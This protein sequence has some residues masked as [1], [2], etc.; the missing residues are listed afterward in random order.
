MHW[1]RK[2]Q[3]TPV[4]LPGESQGQGSLGGLP[5]MGSHRVGHVWS[6]LA[7]AGVC[8]GFT[9]ALHYF[10]SKKESSAD[11][12]SHALSCPENSIWAKKHDAPIDES[13]TVPHCFLVL[14]KL[15]NI[16]YIGSKIWGQIALL[17]ILTLPLRSYVTWLRHLTSLCLHCLIGTLSKRWHL[18]HRLVVQIRF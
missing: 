12:A 9:K 6:H 7:A 13:A 16:I 3:P 2:W 10:T 15:G 17:H 18:T 5:S 1:R 11:T 4:S 14:C 8:I